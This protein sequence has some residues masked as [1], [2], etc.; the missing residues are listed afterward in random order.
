MR[1]RSLLILVIMM[2]CLA[3]GSCAAGRDDDGVSVSMSSLPNVI[4]TN[5]TDKGP[6]A[7][8]SSGGQTC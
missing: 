1:M 2:L 4:V 5:T 7:V 8:S 3:A 6:A